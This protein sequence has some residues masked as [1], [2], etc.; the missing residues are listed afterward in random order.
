VEPT[1]DGVNLPLGAIPRAQR[2]VDTA[3]DRVVPNGRADGRPADRNPRGRD[4]VL[5][6]SC[7]DAN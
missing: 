5:W 1:C 4:V 2:K 6:A 3:R 7:K